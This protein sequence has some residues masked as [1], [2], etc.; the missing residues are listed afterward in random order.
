[1]HEG[2]LKQPDPCSTSLVHEALQLGSEEAWALR[3]ALAA[4]ELRADVAEARAATAQARVSDD[5][6]LI[7]HLKLQIAKLQRAEYGQRF[8][9]GQRLLD[10]YELQLEE[11]EAS[12]TFDDLRAEMAAARTT[13][14]RGFRPLPPVTPAFP[15]APAPR[16]GRRARAGVVRRLRPRVIS[17]ILHVFKTGCRRQDCRSD[18]G[19][20]TIYN[21]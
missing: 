1:M 20:H 18:Y 8:E 11:L 4:A 21:R 2:H 14:G 12:A 5:A 15:C 7:A 9:R 10:Q 17:G 6:A 13:Y 19:P 16:A 3:A